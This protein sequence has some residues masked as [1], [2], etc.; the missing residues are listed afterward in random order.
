MIMMFGQYYNA[1]FH[2]WYFLFYFIAVEKFYYMQLQ[3]WY[4]GMK[5][6]LE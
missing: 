5:F 1:F 3:L 6:N 4:R 2:G